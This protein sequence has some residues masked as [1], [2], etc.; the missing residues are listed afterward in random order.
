MTIQYIIL[1]LIALLVGGYILYHLYQML[2]G[3]KKNDGCASGSCNGCS[4]KDKEK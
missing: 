1:A 2:W 3:E 4:V